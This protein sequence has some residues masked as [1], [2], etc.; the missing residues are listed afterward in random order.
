VAPGFGGGLLHD[1]A[2][3]GEVPVQKLFDGIIHRAFPLPAPA[4]VP[5]P[6][7]P[8]RRMGQPPRLILRSPPHLFYIRLGDTRV[9]PQL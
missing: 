8:S 9:F 2:D 7:A 6:L 4:S 5:H 1:R 3:G